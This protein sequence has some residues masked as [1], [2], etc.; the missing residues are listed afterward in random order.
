MALPAVY[1]EIARRFHT[2]PGT[3]FISFP[4]EVKLIETAISAISFWKPVALPGGLSN[5]G[6][7]RGIFES[8]F[9]L[10]SGFL[11][12][13]LPRPALIFMGSIIWAAGLIGCAFSPDR[14]KSQVMSG[15]PVFLT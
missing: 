14:P 6:L 15:W 12:D 8:I 11:A 3:H 5:L 10:P 13:R 2:T 4:W 1:A 7:V 9:A